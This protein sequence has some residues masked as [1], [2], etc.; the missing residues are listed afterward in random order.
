MATITATTMATPG[1]RTVTETTL[2]AS[3]TLPYDPSVNGSILY[4]RN[5]TGGA[6]S[7]TINGSQA[8][9]SILVAGYGTLSLAGG[10]AV[11]SIPAGQARA[12]RLDSVSLYLQGTI[13]ITGGTGLVASYLQ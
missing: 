8:P 6:L 4:L 5:P 3:D 9:A 2:T 1:V 13:T 10:L 11:G 12:I 7:P